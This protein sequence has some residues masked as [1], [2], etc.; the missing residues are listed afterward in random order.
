MS[1]QTK[2]AIFGAAGSTDTR[3]SNVLKDE[4][5][6]EGPYV[7]A[8]AR[9]RHRASMGARRN[10]GRD[11]E[12]GSGREASDFSARWEEGLRRRVVIAG[13]LQDYGDII[14]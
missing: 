12:G 2:I 9:G 4:A 3:F 14:G 11:Q 5:A 10:H 13:Y 1:K 6:Y 7:E 8:S